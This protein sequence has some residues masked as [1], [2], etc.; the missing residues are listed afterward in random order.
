MFPRS[1]ST[2][3]A[4]DLLVTDG[5][6]V[7]VVAA[8]TGT[9]YG[10]E[11]T[12]G[13]IYTIAGDGN[14]QFNGDGV[15]ATTAGM[16]PSDAVA[17]PEAMVD[18][19]RL[20]RQPE[21]AAAGGQHRDVLR[22]GNDSRRHLHDRRRGTRGISGSGDPAVDAELEQPSAAAVDKSGNV[23]FADQ[24]ANVVWVVAAGIGMFYGLP[25]TAGDIYVVAGNGHNLGDDGLGDGGPAAGSTL[26]GQDGV[27]IDPQ[28]PCW[29]E[30]NSTTASGQYRADSTV[31][32]AATGEWLCA[33]ARRSP[34]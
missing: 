28:E 17:D 14:S 11:M 32:I 34:R 26:N 27:A 12:A 24:D 4:G 31:R 30:M 7:R 6:R 10:R 15:P 13:D 9:F 20:Q 23:V 8:S 5:T 18:R 25:M 33:G 22:P 19:H 2:D 1:V 3:H 29:S 16:S 21:S